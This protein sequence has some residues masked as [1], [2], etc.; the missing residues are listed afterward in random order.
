MD[1]KKKLSF[2]N[3]KMN[4]NVNRSEREVKNKKMKELER[5]PSWKLCQERALRIL[6][7]CK[8]QLS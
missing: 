7:L 1:Y 3:N 2:P 5:W 4:I 6:E 8:G